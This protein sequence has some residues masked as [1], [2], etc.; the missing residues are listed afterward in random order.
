MH[1]QLGRAMLKLLPPEAL[2]DNLFDLLRQL[3]AYVN[4][5]FNLGIVSIVYRRFGTVLSLLELVTFAQW[6]FS[7]D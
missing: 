7:D 3:N 5:I 6:Y 2:E 1:L 4:V